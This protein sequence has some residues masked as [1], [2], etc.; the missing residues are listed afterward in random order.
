MSGPLVVTVLAVTTAMA[1]SR[2]LIPPRRRLATRLRPYAGLARS[3]LGTGYADVSVASLVN[4]DDR[5]VV[6]RVFEP[7]SVRLAAQLGRLLDTG[8]AE[9]LAL[10]LR[11]AGFENSDPTAYRMR[12]LAWTVCG[13]ILG[14]TLGVMVLESASG[15]LLMLVAFGFPASILQRNR[16]ESAIARRRLRMRVEVYTIAQ[17]VAVHLRTGYGPV[18][19]IRS[20]CAVGSGPVI[21][22]LREVLSWMSGGVMPRAAYERQAAVTP[23][24]AAARLYRLLGASA[25]SGGDIGPSLLAAAVD[26][27]SERRDELARSAVRRRTAMLVP[28]LLL[29]APVMVLFV[30]AALPSL[31]MGPVR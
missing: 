5:S 10:R 30:G 26:Q 9:T 14:G 3:R 11:Q 29:I 19:A 21:E 15:T 17:L 12:Q 18:Q 24:P 31:V 23:E 27:R 8:D 1:T 22:E 25:T 4:V 7:T 28:L 2:V 16:L 20:V 13:L 6:R